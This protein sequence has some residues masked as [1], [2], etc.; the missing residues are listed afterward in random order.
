MPALGDIPVSCAINVLTSRRCC[1]VNLRCN[2][3]TALISENLRCTPVSISGA[4]VSYLDSH[5]PYGLIMSRC[6]LSNAT[7]SVHK[8]TNK[9]NTNL[10]N[11]IPSTTIYSACGPA[12]SRRGRG[13]LVSPNAEAWRNE[14]LHVLGRV[15]LQVCIYCSAVYILVFS[16][17]SGIYSGVY[18]LGRI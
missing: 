9:Q 10:P 7:E 11:E 12:P 1:G 17:Y 16:I 3:V 5:H 4:A 13:C 18:T 6:L 2:G 14:M 15:H 8:Q